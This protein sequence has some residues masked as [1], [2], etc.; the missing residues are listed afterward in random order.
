MKGGEPGSA[1]TVGT[2]IPN[3]EPGPDPALGV[4][5]LPGI[6]PQTG[7]QNNQPREPIMNRERLVD[8]EGKGIPELEPP[9]G[10]VWVKVDAGDFVC[11]L[12][13]IEQADSNDGGGTTYYGGEIRI[14]NDTNVDIIIN[15]TGNDRGDDN[16]FWPTTEAVLEALFVFVDGVPGLLDADGEQDC[17]H[18]KG[19]HDEISR[20]IFPYAEPFLVFVQSGAVVILTTVGRFTHK[21]PSATAE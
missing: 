11:W 6:V 14:T 17:T 15:C 21:I 19:F 1:E 9:A 20:C 2:V 18:W 8:G 7:R 4:F 12:D 13:Y 5:T 10:A 3:R 16:C